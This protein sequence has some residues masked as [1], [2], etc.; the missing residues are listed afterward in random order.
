VLLSTQES[1]ENLNKNNKHR[2][3]LPYTFSIEAKANILF[4]Q[5]KYYVQLIITRPNSKAII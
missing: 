4:Q 5:V 1:S 3:L 2:H